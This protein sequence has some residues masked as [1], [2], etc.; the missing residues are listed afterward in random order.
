MRIEINVENEIAPN[1]HDI[2][3]SVFKEE[4]LNYWFSGGR[5]STKSS[6]IS[7]DIIL[8]ILNHPNVNALAMRKIG[9]TLRE[10][11]Y[12]QIIWAIDKLQIAHKFIIKLSPLEI[13][14]KPTGQRI[15]FRGGD[16]PVKLKSVKPRRGYI[17]ITWFEEVTEFNGME[18][19]RNITQSTNR[20][21]SKFWNFHSYN[22]PK[23]RDNW[24]NVEASE[25]ELKDDTVWHHSTY[26]TVPAEW[27]GDEF[28]KAADQLKRLKPQ[29][30]NH[31]YMGIATGTGGQIFDNIK[32]WEATEKAIR[33]FDRF[34]FG[35]DFGFAADPF[36]W[37]KFH[38]DKKRKELYVIDE[39]YEVRLHDNRAV[40]K[41]RQKHQ[42]QMFITADSAESKSISYMQNQGLN[43][44]SAKKGKDSRHYGYK[45]LQDL[46]AIYIDKKRTPNA[47]REFTL[48]EYHQDRNG[49]FIS[50]YPDKNDHF[51]DCTRYA[52]ESE[53]MQSNI[54]IS[55]RVRI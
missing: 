39:I 31:E 47:Y 26:L 29:T 43:I 42:G 34:K 11:V 55:N 27:L 32:S 5:A 19:I 3:K 9:A 51:L 2:T 13:V 46:N 35:I 30:Y 45:F 20:G 7:L 54:Y 12:N 28:I 48:Y 25:V 18:E 16:D 36:A 44:E 24:V 10:S 6:N 38:Y 53:M 21:G 22:P 41:I 33:T 1:F 40:E 15:Y 4:Y 17:G 37:G 49:N 8:L 23:S 52:M 14:Y 50:E